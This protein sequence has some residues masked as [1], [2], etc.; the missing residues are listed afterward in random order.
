VIKAFCDNVDKLL[1]NNAGLSVVVVTHMGKDPTKGAI[2]HSRF[3]G[4]LDTEITVVKNQKMLSNKELH[5]VG[6][7]VEKTIVPLEFTYPIHKLS[8]IERAANESK[9]ETASKFVLASL[10]SSPLTEQQLRKD[11]KAHQI[12]D[13]AFYTALRNLIDTKKIESMPTGGQGNRKIIK[14]GGGK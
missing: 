11:A 1:T 12:T 2:G 7:D 10:Q 5:I 14:L 3:S 6:R 9:V 4:W 8:E 13:Y